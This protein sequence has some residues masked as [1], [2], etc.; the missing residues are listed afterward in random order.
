MKVF[1]SWLLGVPLVMVLS[2]QAVYSR[3]A[4]EPPI[5]GIDEAVALALEQ[6]SVSASYEYR[7]LS[8]EEQATASSQLPDPKLK[9][10]AANF[11][12]DTF[13]R[14]QEPM[15]Q[16][17]VGIIQAFPRGDSLDIRSEINR[18]KAE[19][20]RHMA[21]D[22]RLQA[23]KETMRDWLELYYWL[24]AE[25]T[26]KQSIGFFRKLVVVTE[27]RYRVGSVTQQDVVQSELELDRLADRLE[28]IRIKQDMA[29]SR[30]S[31][32]I[33]DASH[34]PLPDELPDL[35]VPSLGMD[36]RAAL[37]RHPMILARDA[38]LQEKSEMVELSRQQYKP[39]W[40]LD[41]TYGDR[42]GTNPDGSDRSDFLSAKVLVDIPIFTNKRQD[43]Q[44]ASSQRNLSAA[45]QDRETAV[46]KLSSK[47]EEANATLR[48]LDRQIRLYRDRLVPQSHSHSELALKA[49]EN[50]RVEF[51]SVMRARIAEL[52]TRL[53]ALRLEVDRART[54]AT[55]TYL[56]GEKK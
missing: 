53:K 38:E 37:A 50:S 13:S 31:R 22:A 10:G 26:V 46:R 48:I 49:Y 16:L 56:A 21:S 8:F 35:D 18:D 32:W 42:T 33:G 9:L 14:S 34:R 4:A 5:L 40:A 54:I 55:L 12:T 25:K 41:V 43:R 29:R 1:V 6:E 23:R 3:P 20:S 47:L 27:S 36:E 52:D 2:V 11:P 44:L 30:L 45:E 39:G 28:S 7:A 15:T 24:Q 51:N 17:Q 19:M